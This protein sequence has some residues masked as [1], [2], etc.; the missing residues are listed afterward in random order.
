MREE[1]KDE[2][3]LAEYKLLCEKHKRGITV[4]PGWRFSQDGND[5]R[6][7]LNTGVARHDNI[8]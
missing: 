5:F 1:K 6:L 2:Q 7:V 3:F 4:V 8:N